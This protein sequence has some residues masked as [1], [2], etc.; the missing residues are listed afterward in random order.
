MR[1]EGREGIIRPALIGLC[2]SLL[3]ILL[4]VSSYLVSPT[5]IPR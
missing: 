4:F 5:V 3:T 1:W 2:L